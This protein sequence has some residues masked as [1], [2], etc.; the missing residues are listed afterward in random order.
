MYIGGGSHLNYTA[1]NIYHIATQF[2]EESGRKRFLDK[3]DSILTPRLREKGM[4]WEYFVQE[5][6]IDLWGIN[7]TIPPELGSELWKQWVQQNR[8]VEGDLCKDHS[9]GLV[10]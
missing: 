9:K 7:S 1:I 5:T 8:L 2:K 4:D 6:P 3:V 10:T